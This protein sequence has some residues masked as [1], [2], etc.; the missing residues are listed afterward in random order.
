MGGS[1]FFGWGA[2]AQCER[3]ELHSRVATEADDF[4]ELDELDDI[5]SPVLYSLA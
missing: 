4:E 5:Y 1:S 3:S 2:P